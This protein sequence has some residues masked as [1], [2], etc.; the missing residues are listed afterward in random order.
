M[1]RL[2]ALTKLGI[3][4]H[5]HAIKQHR[6]SHSLI[7]AIAAMIDFATAPKAARPKIPRDKDTIAKLPFGPGAVFER[8]EQTCSDVIQ[9]RPYDS[10]S[11]GRLGKSMCGIQ[12][13]EL[14]D[15]ERVA[16]WIQ[17]GGLATWPSKVVWNHVVR[18]FSTWVA[19]ARAWEEAGG[20][21]T[22]ASL[23]ADAWR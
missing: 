18:H 7:E 12:G 14:D 11:F 23:G 16:S 10:L 3:N 20:Q 15:L 4:T 13:L 6:A 21:N 1:T 17:S 19:Y 8:L 9:M 22:P 2:E 5:A